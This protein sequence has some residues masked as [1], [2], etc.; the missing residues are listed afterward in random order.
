MIKQVF[1]L[2]C[3]MLANSVC[4]S[5][6]LQWNGFKLTEENDFLSLT[7]RGLDRYYTQ[8]LQFEFCYTTQR[9]KF[10]EK[11]LIPASSWARN[12]YSISIAQQIFTPRIT[13]KHPSEFT[14]VDMP[15]AGNLYIKQQLNSYDSTKRI[16]FTS[17]FLL[18]MVG[19]IS[20]GEHT[21][22]F[23]HKIIKNNPAVGWATQI[24][25]D[26]LINYSFRVEKKITQL[27]L[28]ALEAKAEAKAG[29][30]LISGAAG[31][32]L[33]LGNWQKSDQ[34]SW[35][36]FFLPEV[37]AVAYNAL[38]QG[39]II[40]RLSGGNAQ[41]PYFLNEIKPVV[42]THSTGFQVRY[43][44]FE[45]LYRQVNITREFSSQLPHYYG[46]AT[47]TFWFRGHSPFSW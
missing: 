2:V 11:I 23:F 7:Q 5:Q 27:N 46:S 24:P 39:G 32:N 18:G 33:K 8:G 31:L 13:N 47:L 15:Y 20:L 42:Y 38:L 16:R 34:F 1:V 29:T 25:N 44:R 4:M 22:A 26:V 45:L 3:L 9:P 17:A 35:E 40:N 14:G 37:R 12:Q 10:L 21:Q 19:P 28:F 43:K 41:T 30:L 36:V 6:R